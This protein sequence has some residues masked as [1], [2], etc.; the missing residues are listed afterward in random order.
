MRAVVCKELGPVE[1]LVL[2]TDWQVGAPGPD[3][4]V[5]EL[6]RYADVRTFV[7]LKHAQLTRQVC[8]SKWK[9]GKY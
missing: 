3:E 2:D 9:H 1:K 6:A 8:H 4:V 7:A 5:I